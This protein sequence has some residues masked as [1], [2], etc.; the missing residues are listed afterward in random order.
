MKVGDRA[1]V[2]DSNY[3]EV[4]GEWCV[5]TELENSESPFAVTVR[6]DKTNLG[7]GSFPKDSIQVL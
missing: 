6:F 3:P 5:I 4:Y 2:V 7:F 1:K